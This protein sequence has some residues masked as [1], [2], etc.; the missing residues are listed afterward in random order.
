V[1]IKGLQY[2]ATSEPNCLQFINKRPELLRCI[3]L[4]KA[5]HLWIFFSTHLFVCG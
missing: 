4:K 1:I 5:T 2:G 3:V